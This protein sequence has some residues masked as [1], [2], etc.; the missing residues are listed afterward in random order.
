[1]RDDLSP[2][3]SV[4]RRR[5]SAAPGTIQT[6]PAALGL[7]LLLLFSAHAW[8]ETPSFSK[9]IAPL[10]QQRCAGCHAA[11][12]HMGGLTVD[13]FDALMKGGKD[14]K[15]IAPGKAE[16]SRLFQ[17]VTGKV[18]PAM[19]MDGTTLKAEEI[20]SLKA[21]ID[22]GAK[23]PEA[24]ETVAV[25]VAEIPKIEP[26]SPLKPQI[27]DLAWRPGGHLIA[28]AGYKEVRLI[29]PSS[30]QVKAK[31]EGEEGA[32]RAIAFSRD[33]KLLAAAG[34]LP[35]QHGQVEIWDVDT[36]KRIQT[37]SGHADCIYGVAFSPDGKSIATSSYDRLIKLW[38]VATGA[39]IRTFKDHI[40]AIYAIAFTPDGKH[41]ISGAADRTIKFWDVAT[42][43]RLY[44]LSEPQD[45]INAIALDPTGPR[46]AA[47]GLDKTIRVWTLGEKAGTLDNSL[48]AHE[49]AILRL[50]WSPDGKMLLS[51][52][53]D[54]TVKLLNA[55][56]LSEIGTLPSQ[57][58]WVYGLEFSPD[59]SEFAAGRFDGSLT[60]EPV[61]AVAGKALAQVK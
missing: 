35:A 37:I 54:G 45:G 14:G 28:L 36:R 13:T 57:S 42:G 21:W 39:E 55:S 6:K 59:G 22:G 32:V 15:V 17:M 12:V 40:E 3:I 44:T 48:I 51:S 16:D 24:G 23:G 5:L 47:G 7:G 2:D 1:M 60:I 34:G 61:K 19:P 41:L 27:F 8:A 58:D 49:D 53:A 56:D 50:A 52:S 31:L 46:L 9:S 43:E 4:D 20:E 11:S 10:L 33:G 38:D 26:R 30:Q 25:A 18:A 29:D